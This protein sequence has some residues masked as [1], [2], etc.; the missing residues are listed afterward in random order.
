MRNNRNVRT[1]EQKQEILKQVADSL[2][3]GKTLK[4]ALEG[5]GVHPTSYYQW[6][7]AAGKSTRAP[8]IPRLGKADKQ[9]KAIANMLS[10]PLENFGKTILA[11][12]TPQDI[13][14]ILDKMQ[15]LQ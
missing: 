7:R 9:N 11:V 13:M 10:I 6:T 4:A 3:T 12:G 5:V 8:K 2:A 15:R 14:A 1:Q